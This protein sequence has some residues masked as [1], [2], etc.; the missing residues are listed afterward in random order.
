WPTTA[1]RAP[2]SSSPDPRTGW[3]G[4]GLATPATLASALQ[5]GEPTPDTVALTRLQRELEARLPDR[6]A[7]AHADGT[8]GVGRIFG[9]EDR[10]VLVATGR[11]NTP[12]EVPGAHGSNRSPGEMVSNRATGAAAR[13][14][15]AGRTG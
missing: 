8:G 1:S 12:L 9:E 3:S 15:P 10:G 4:G 6:A 7:G 11:V 5:L 13:V 2:P 14:F